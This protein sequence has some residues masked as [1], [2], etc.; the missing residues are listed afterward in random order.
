M[1]PYMF[2]ASSSPATIATSLAADSQAGREPERRRQLSAPIRPA[3]FKGFKALGLEMGC[4][5]VSPVIAVK[6]HG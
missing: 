3:L 4:D 2:T 6:L 5:E 1:R